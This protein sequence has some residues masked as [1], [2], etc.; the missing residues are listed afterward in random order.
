MALANMYRCMNISMYCL[1]VGFGFKL[2]LGIMYICII[3]EC[4]YAY[5]Y[6][7]IYACMHA[8]MYV[9]MYVCMDACMHVSIM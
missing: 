3:Y 7:C 5:M 1:Y 6:V 2:E 9:L 4:I 8:C